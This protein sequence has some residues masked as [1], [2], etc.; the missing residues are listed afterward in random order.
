MDKVTPEILVQNEL[1]AEYQPYFSY[2]NGFWSETGC[3][4]PV[5]MRARR[6]VIYVCRDADISDENRAILLNLEKT[7]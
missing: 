7:T 6:C 3:S 1:P 4:L 2:P 5:E